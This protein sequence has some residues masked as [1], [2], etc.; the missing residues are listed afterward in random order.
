MREHRPKHSELPPQARQRANTRAYANVYQQ[1]GK[2]IPKP[3][4]ECGAIAQKHHD[5]YR[6]PLKVRWLCR[7]HHL[8]HHREAA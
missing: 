2:L 6:K 1:R 8:A 3:C 4:E 7:E 5:D